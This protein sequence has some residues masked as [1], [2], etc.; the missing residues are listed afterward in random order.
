MIHKLSDTIYLV[1]VPEGASG[2]FEHNGYAY[3]DSLS[4]KD[5][6][7][8]L[9]KGQWSIAGLA[10]ECTEEQAKGL[11]LA[12]KKKGFATIYPSYDEIGVFTSGA[13]PALL[14]FCRS[15]GV[16]SERLLIIKKK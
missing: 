16:P 15:V 4:K 13:L 3:T 9:P 7:K 14:S 8:K 2:F 6:Y 1:E 10:S 5:W 12:N 11:V